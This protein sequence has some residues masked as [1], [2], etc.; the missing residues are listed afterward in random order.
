MVLY[1]FRRVQHARQWRSEA[2]KGGSVLQLCASAHFARCFSVVAKVTRSYRQEGA[3]GCFV[4]ARAQMTAREAI[5]V[6]CT[7][8]VKLAP[9][10]CCIAIALLYKI[11]G[12]Y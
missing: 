4:Q 6:G 7:M 10:P 1:L 2:S 9:P 11:C 5:C 8:C 3:E 12:H